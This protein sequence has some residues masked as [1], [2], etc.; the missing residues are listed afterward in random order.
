MKTA[1]VTLADAT[2]YLA[3]DGEAMFTLRDDFGGTQLALEAIEQ[4]TRE[5]FAATCAIAAVLAERGELLRR[6]LGYDPGAIPEKDDFLLMVRPFEIV[7]LKRAIMTAIELG[8]GRE[9]TSPADDEID[10]GLAELNQKKNKIRR[11]EY[12]RMISLY[13]SHAV[14]RWEEDESITP[15]PGDVVFYD[16]QDSG[17]G[18]DRGAADHVG[19]VSSVSG[20]VLKVIEG[21]FSNSVKERTLEVNGKYLRGFGLP[22][23]YT[24][25][26]NKEDFDMDINEARKQLTSC[27]DT[28]DTPSAWAKEAA[29]YCKRKGIFNGDGAGNFGW[30]QPITREAVACIIYRAL[31]AAGALG[32]LSDV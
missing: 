27:A 28:G 13:R 22:A 32:N 14:S 6:R 29:E 26:D 1:K 8:Y 9:V 12:Y 2:Y 5:S 30:Q 3:F 10:E 31:E 17:S 24:K 15:Q 20:R 11:A 23:Y 18:D 19:I 16:W 25:T 21:N 4:D 7:T